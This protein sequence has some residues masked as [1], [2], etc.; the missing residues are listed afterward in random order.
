MKTSK[1][2]MY[3]YFYAICIGFL[4]FILIF[5]F[6]HVGSYY[7][8]GV[9][10]SL[11]AIPYITWIINR[12][13]TAWIKK[14]KINVSV[15]IMAQ[16]IIGIFLFYI[17]SL[18][19]RFVGHLSIFFHEVSHILAALSFNVRIQGVLFLPLEGKTFMNPSDIG[20]LTA[21]EHTIVAASGGCGV[22]VIGIIFLLLLHW[23][24]GISLIYRAP[25][26]LLIMVAVCSDL[27]YFGNGAITLTND[28]GVIIQLN[29]SILPGFIAL[30][31][32]TLMVLVPIFVVWS[33]F[34][35]AK[36]MHNENEVVL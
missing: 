20:N 17:W 16:L 2:M 6:N 31:S 12:Y 19:D 25:L 36:E 28:M 8:I 4:A 5:T 9:I 22:I 27:F 26:Y 11:I 15:K 13:F 32:L 3:K 18:I 14:K 34:K 24:K 33:L 30:V 21:M 7:M 1:E 29:P 23:N 35:R 10:A